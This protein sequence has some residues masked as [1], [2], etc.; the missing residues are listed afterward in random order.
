MKIS[1]GINGYKDYNV[2]EK[3]E[4]LCID[5]L[6]KLK[7]KNSN[8]ELYNVCFDN[9]NI[10]YDN[11]TTLS[12]LKIRSNKLIYDYFQHDGL[13]NEYELRKSEIDNNKKELPSVKEIF[14][15]L[16]N[17]DCDYFLFLNND[18]IL[19]NR[20]FKEIEQGIECYPI[21]RMHIEDID[22]LDQ[23]PILE[24]YSV[25]GF[26]TFLVKKSVWLEIRNSF[27]DLILGRF[28]WD[29]YFFTMFNLLCKCKNINKLPPVC[30]HIEHGSTS[31][32]NSI[33]NYYAEDVFKRNL[34]I[35]HLWFSYVQNVLLK[36]PTV[37]NCKWYQ[38]FPEESTLERQHFGN[39]KA[40]PQAY[41]KNYTKEEVSDST[42][43]DLF[44]PIAEKD[45]LKLKYVIEYAKA[46]LDAKNIFIC[47]PHTIK[48]K[49]S[50]SS[51]IYINDKDILDIPDKSFIS[52]RPNWTYQ[53]FL[54]MFFNQSTSEYYFALDSDT[55]ILKK[56]DLFE[57]KQPIWYY[58]WK[59]NHFPYFHFNKN[60][61]NLNKSLNHTGIG[62]LGLFN[63]KV[64]KSFLDRTGSL[65]AKSLLKKIGPNLNVVYHFSEYETYANFVN[66]FYPGLYTFKHLEQ[67]NEGRDLNQGQNWCNIDI[68]IA[69]EKAK[70]TDKS[71]LSIHSWKI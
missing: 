38:P 37:N 39:F 67:I 44:I 25:H 36:R 15:V 18:I 50:D 21:S 32:E 1:I 48:N 51:I 71:I 64:T 8:I 69:I 46:N 54:K 47:S 60:T 33:E 5:S 35:G 42:D 65:T 57:D 70:K 13:K 49:I 66:E 31:M 6:L 56:L 68:E 43:Y 16:A 11:F 29:T 3:R 4:R 7:N 55:I 30:F 20:L 24:S 27:E 63:K 14:D 10:L 2:L 19:S 34:I 23:I 41:N 40:L 61:F 28:Y 17:T 62:D 22:S 52:F 9:E 58:G 53:Q 26:D 12:K 45:E 59:Q